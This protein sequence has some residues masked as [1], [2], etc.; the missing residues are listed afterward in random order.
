MPKK[1]KKCFYS[2]DLPLNA[3]AD[4]VKAREKVLIKIARAKALK[5]GYSSKNKVEK[6]ATNANTILDY[7]SKNGVCSEQEYYFNTSPKAIVVQ[8]C[9]LGCVCIVAFVGFISLI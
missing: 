9:L 3:N 6:I 5:K 8:L 7:I 2:L 1:V 4:Q